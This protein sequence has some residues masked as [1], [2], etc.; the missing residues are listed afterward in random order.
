M[1]FLFYFAI[2]ILYCYTLYNLY[3]LDQEC[4]FHEVLVCQVSKRERTLLTMQ[5]HYTRWSVST[6]VL[7][8]LLRNNTRDLESDKSAGAV[9]LAILLGKQYAC[10]LYCLLLM[11]PYVVLCILSL[12][13]SWILVFPLV[14]VPLA[15]RLSSQCFRGDLVMIPQ[16]T[17]QLNL[18]FGLLYLTS[19]A[20]AS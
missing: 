9:T 3:I 8:R 1:A 20:L 17:A 18:S 19:L 11:I 16:G 12:S 2:T 7:F 15:A 13:S 14:T 10:V 5:V 4:L 6:Q